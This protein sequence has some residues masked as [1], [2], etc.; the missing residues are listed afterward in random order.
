MLTSAQVRYLMRTNKVTI[1]ALAARMDITLKRVRHV[2]EHGTESPAIS[3]DWVEA[4]TVLAYPWE[5]KI[6]FSRRKALTC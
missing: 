1:R 5:K 6:G 4:I 3:Q 2:R